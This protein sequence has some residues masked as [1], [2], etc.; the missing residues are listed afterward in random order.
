MLSR[1]VVHAGANKTGSSAIQSFLAHN[2]KALREEGFVVPDATCGL[3]SQI[4]GYQ[5]FYLQE[6]MSAPDGP[7]RL[8]RDVAAVAEAAGS[9][10]TLILSGEN[11]AA[12][13]AA[14]TLFA[15]LAKTYETRLVLYVRRQDDYLLSS[16][17]QWYSKDSDDFWAWIVGA[18]G[19]TGNWATYLRRWGEV[20]PNDRIT[21][22]VFEPEKLAG[23]DAV[24]DFAGCIGVERPFER[25]FRPKD[26]VNPSF[27]EA[28]LDLVAG[29]DF[30]FDNV[31]DNRFYAFVQ[32][33]TGEAFFKERGE[34]PITD[35]QRRAIIDHY[36][37][38]NA[39][40]RKTFF[41]DMTGQL[42]APLKEGDYAYVPPEARERKQREFLISMVYALR[43][44][45]KL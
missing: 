30:I 37:P 3:T 23:G 20:L 33:L 16:W 4:T 21:V 38:S 39:W 26:R 43:K 41:P 5:V 27:T 44:R 6:L 29:N 45:G 19:K 35:A 25:F 22:R 42:F 17:Q 36:G 8:E 2:H 40:V 15:T 9:A 32:E 28:V 12:N 34:S 7:A 14:P 24:R 18:L 31:H 13:P 1:L 11:L 10:H